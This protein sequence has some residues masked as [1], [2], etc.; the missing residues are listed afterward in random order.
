MDGLDADV[1][2]HA[3][4]TAREFGFR[5][6]RIQTGEGKFRAVLDPYGEEPDE[7]TFVAEGHA[8]VESGPA[9][10]DLTATA[11][12]YFTSEN[13][14]VGRSVARGDRI[15]IITA[16]GLPNDVGSSH[17]GEVVEVCVADGDAVEYGQVLAVVEL[18]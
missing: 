11:V 9:R 12:G 17:A 6:V 18:K 16:L 3:L 8:L 4:R 13:L 5:S 7:P 10:S 2:R 1:I 15:G 14:T